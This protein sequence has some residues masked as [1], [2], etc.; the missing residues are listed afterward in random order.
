MSPKEHSRIPKK[1]I[2]DDNVDPGK[3]YSYGII[4]NRYSLNIKRLDITQDITPDPE[5][6]DLV[7][8]YEVQLQEKM[9]VI[10]AQFNTEMDVHFESVR[11][12]ETRIGNFLTDMMRKQVEADV[13]ILNGGSIRAGKIYKAGKVTIGDWYDILPYTNSI[14]KVEITGEILHKIL[15]NGVSQYPKLDGRFLQVS[16][17]EFKFDPRKE[18]GNR[19]LKED[20]LIDGKPLD[21][22]KRYG[23]ACNEFIADGKEGFKPILEGEQ[24]IDEEAAPKLKQI[25]DDFFGKDFFTK[26][27][28]FRF[29]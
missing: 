15:E 17:I 9:K 5:I 23:V 8:K 12:R 21:Y 29:G 28:N 22:Q 27:S 11:T 25:L 19:I 18:P 7:Q 6:E 20:V 10:N 14:L 26:I 3:I 1:P 2:T 24:I 16:R 4:G 13:A